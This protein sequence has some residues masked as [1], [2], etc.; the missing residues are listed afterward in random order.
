MPDRCHDSYDTYFWTMSGFFCSHTEG[1][2]FYL[3]NCRIEM[4]G[5]LASRKYSKPVYS[6]FIKMTVDRSCG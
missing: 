3:D 5:K 4:T 2:G 6:T 1:T